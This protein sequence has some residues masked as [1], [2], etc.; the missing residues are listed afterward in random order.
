MS[1]K[2]KNSFNSACIFNPLAPPWFPHRA[3]ARGL[4][5]TARSISIIL[6][7][8]SPG[9]TLLTPPILPPTKR[10]TAVKKGTWK[11]MYSPLREQ[12]HP[13]WKNFIHHW[14][15]TLDTSPETTNSPK[16]LQTP[17][18]PHTQ[19]IGLEIKPTRLPSLSSLRP[20]NPSWSLTRGSFHIKMHST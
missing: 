3:L 19:Q 14:N 11:T 6:T 16:I 17:S 5:R 13:C 15:Q 4:W 12:T 20:S 18:L 9:M 10:V 2:K 7:S 1:E 8:A